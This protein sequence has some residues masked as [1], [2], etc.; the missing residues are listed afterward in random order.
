M[1]NDRRENPIPQGKYVPATRAG[2]FIFT[3]G[4]TPREKGVLIF[5]G[6]VKT[7]L[8]IENY[9]NA[10]NQA[11]L[12]AL[13]AAKNMLK[14]NERIERVLSIMVFI[15][16]EEDFTAHSKIADFAS[17]FLSHE[18]GEAG[19][20]SRAAIGVSSLPGNAPVEIQMVL[21]TSILDV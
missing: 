3:A 14:Y 12:N 13:T 17:E 15:N 1:S 5:E 7:A 18:I 8:S 4:M 9:R 11:T 6:K 2:N 21:Y 16:S 10:V 19:I 20:G